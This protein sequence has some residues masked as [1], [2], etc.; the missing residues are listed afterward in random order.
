MAAAVPTVKV[1]DHADPRCVWRPGGEQHAAHA[2]GA[3][4]VGA[5]KTVG[6]PMTTLV[7]EVNVE[8]GELRRKA[9]RVVAAADAA[10]AALPV[11]VIT[12]GQRAARAPPR[13]EVAAVDAM[14]RHGAR[15]LSPALA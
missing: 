8:I 15:A 12:R 11:Q 6:V 10:V 2:V 14:H 13:D 3:V 4:R 5:Q 9:V 1:S 7:E